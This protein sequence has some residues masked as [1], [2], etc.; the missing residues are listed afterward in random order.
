M[1]YTRYNKDLVKNTI[2]CDCNRKK[3]PYFAVVTAEYRIFEH[4]FI[5]RTLYSELQNRLGSNKALIVLGPRQVGKTTLLSALM[6]GKSVLF[7]NGD[8]PIVRQILTNINTEQ[9]KQLIGTH[10]FL[11]IDEAQRIEGIGLTLKL[12]TDQIK[13]CQ[14][15]VSGSSA[16]ELRNATHEPLTGRK[17]EYQLFPISWTEFEAHVG[18]LQA[19]QQLE[20]RLIYGFYP[21]VITQVGEE[22]EVLFQ[23]SE[24]YL[25]KDLFT[26]GAKLKR[27]ELLPKILQALAYQLGSEVSHN[28]IAQLVGADNETIRTYIDLLIKSFVIF[29]LQS[30]SRNLRNEIKAK[31]KYYFYDNGIRNAVIGNFSPLANR[32]DIGALWENFLISEKKKENHYHLRHANTYFWRTTGQQEIDY[33]E[34]MDGELKAFEFKWKPNAKWRVPKLFL[35]TYTAEL[36]KIDRSNFRSFLTRQTNE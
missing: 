2:S 7:L 10:E 3:T 11:F 17:W 6:N 15:V 21:E 24:S 18:F 9:L 13:S 8:D 33:L 28:E 29:P 16:F 36:F 14:V 26:I 1:C 22:R 35:N 30:F 4:M 27:P 32:N 12:I 19:E 23:L 5:Q 20:M 34:E 31:R 25:Y